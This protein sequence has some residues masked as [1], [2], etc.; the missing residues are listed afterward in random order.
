MT[1]LILLLYMQYLNKAQSENDT[2]LAYLGL[3]GEEQNCEVL[4]KEWDEK[5]KVTHGFFIKRPLH[6]EILTSSSHHL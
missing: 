2:V 1:A 4:D 5:N 3:N 6:L